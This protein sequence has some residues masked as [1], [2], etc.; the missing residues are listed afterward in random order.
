M[1]R[2][3]AEK[4]DRAQLII[5][6]GLAVILSAHMVVTTAGGIARQEAAAEKGKRI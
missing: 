2:K 4:R 1:M 3:E 6:I 5:I